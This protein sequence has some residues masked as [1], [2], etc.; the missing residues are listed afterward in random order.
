MNI[1]GIRAHTRLLTVA[2]PVFCTGCVIDIADVSVDGIDGHGDV[3]ASV[4]FSRR[5]PVEGRT[6]ITIVGTNGTISIQGQEGLAE[7]T[8]RG[9]RT[10]L[11]ETRRE[12]EAYL[13]RVQA[14]VTS[15]LHDIW[16][17][18][19][20]PKDTGGRS[21]RVDYEVSVPTEFMV[22]LQNGNGAVEVLNLA[23]EVRVE[24]GNGNVVLDGL[25]GSSWVSLGN[26]DIR[27]DVTLPAGGVAVYAAGNGGLRLAVQREA[28]ADFSAHVGNGGINVTGLEFTEW[29]SG[30]RFVEG[31]LGS[32][33]GLI[34]LAVGNGWIQVQGG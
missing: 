16:I 8:I 15:R 26:G 19:D 28:S 34:D 25:R 23:G 13:P 20:A 32:G 14:V 18:T 9:R 24:N 11:A 1:K 33:N 7:V 3:E 27:A 10:V 31:K 12:A 17:A 5:I 30:D 2:L 22:T 4:S 29:L 21:Y 6:S